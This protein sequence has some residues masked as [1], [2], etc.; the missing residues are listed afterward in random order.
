MDADAVVHQIR[1]D[2]PFA[3]CCHW[4]CLNYS[5]LDQ[6]LEYCPSPNSTGGSIFTINHHRILSVDIADGDRIS[7][8]WESYSRCSFR[9]SCTMMP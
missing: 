7:A 8:Q 1:M 3:F 4:T 6:C 9:A 5:M 2:S